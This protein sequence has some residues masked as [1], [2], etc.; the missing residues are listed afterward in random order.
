MI[1]A[2]L[3]V[4]CAHTFSVPLGCVV[5]LNYGDDDDDEDDDLVWELEN[6]WTGGGQAGGRAHRLFF[7][8]S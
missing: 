3:V 7:I 6:V 8:A 5:M 2:V 1:C 4:F